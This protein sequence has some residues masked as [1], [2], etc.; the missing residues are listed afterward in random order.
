M[1]DLRFAL[2]TLSRNPGFTT[3]AVLTLALGIGAN[4]AIFTMIN[5]RLLRSLPVKDPQQLVLVTDEGRAS[6]GYPLY[7]QFRDGNQSFSGL[8]AATGL[9]KRRMTVI[10]PPAGRPASIP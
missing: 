10:S 6:L 5:T 1:S 4:T 9:S 3:V 7:E 2:R 8:F